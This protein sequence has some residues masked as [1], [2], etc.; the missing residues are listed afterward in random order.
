MTTQF[1][2]LV[3]PEAE[4]DIDNAVHYYNSVSEGLGS[5]FVNVLDIYFAQIKKVP[6]ASAVQYDEV[7]VK[8]IKVFPFT[9]H[10]TI[11][12]QQIVI[13]KVFNTNQNI[14]PTK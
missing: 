3:S 6:T 9:I 13:L 12:N 8:P 2:L 7:R 1:I 14:T 10:Y 11:E 5:E 4:N